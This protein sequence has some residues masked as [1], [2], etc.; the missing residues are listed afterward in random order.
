M[1]AVPSVFE[2]IQSRMKKKSQDR[3]LSV[4]PDN[5]QKRYKEEGKKSVQNALL[6]QI[7]S[8]NNN[9]QQDN[10][11]IIPEE[12]TKSAISSKTNK[13]ESKF[14]IHDSTS[15]KNFTRGKSM[16]K[17]YRINLIDKLNTTNKIYSFNKAID[18]KKNLNSMQIINEIVEQNKELMDLITGLKFVVLN[19]IGIFMKIILSDDESIKDLL[20]EHLEKKICLCLYD[21]DQDTILNLSER[22][23]TV[24]HFLNKF[25]DVNPFNIQNLGDRI[26]RFPLITTESYENEIYL[27]KMIEEHEKIKIEN[28]NI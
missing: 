24:I 26:F 28:S 20:Q 14:P 4:S 9:N 5:M 23:L 25:E 2:N 21:F 7:F 3:D 13:T 19:K 8:N 18:L 6:K 12:K 10:L 17:I 1:R 11:I 27:K 16:V 15:I 22:K